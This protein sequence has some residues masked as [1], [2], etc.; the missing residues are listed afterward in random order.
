MK[1]STS[2]TLW[3]RLLIACWA[4]I[5]L[6]AN[7]YA[8]PRQ[9]LIHANS[10]KV[11]IRDG[12]IFKKQVWHL[13]PQIKP[14]IYYALEPLGEKKI[15]F[16]TDTDSISFKVTPGKK[17]DFMILLNNKDTCYTRISTRL[18][19]DHV[20]T[21]AQKLLDKRELKQDFTYFRQALEKEHPGLYR[22]KSKKEMDRLFDSCLVALDRPMRGLEFGKSIMFMISSLQDGHTGT[23][24][25]RLIGEYYSENKKMF[26]LTLYF[27]PTK[28]YVFCSN[29]KELPAESELLAIDHQPMHTII[30][31]LFSYL[32][33]D[34][35]IETK[36]RQMLNNGAF[37]YLYN[38]IFGNKSS[39]IVE[40]KTKQGE[41]KISSVGAQYEKE[42]ACDPPKG[43]GNTNKALD[44]QYPQNHVALLTIKTF[45]ENRLN[46]KENFR[47]F[48]ETS[49]QEI[50]TRKI[51]DLIIDLRGNGGGADDLGALLYAYLTSKPFNYF[52]AKESTTQKVS[53]K[54]NPLLGI[55]QPK[56]N[57]F[58][59]DVFFLIDGLS[60]STTADFCAIARSERR[61]KFIGEET[62][63]GY[64]G[65]T[66]GGR[67][68]IQLPNSEIYIIIPTFNYVHAVKKAHYK[69]R[70]I[71]PDYPITPTVSDMIQNK[72]VVLNF[73]LQ[74]A[75]QK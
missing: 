72:D 53:V 39:F 60:F 64:Y 30:K 54:E 41:I 14:D 58:R 20:N 32:S 67:K 11:D 25:P 16:Y 57:N 61:G 55:Q 8:Q 7:V 15:T 47:N 42:F 48:L 74:V 34:G 2:P 37:P 3:D 28:A 4:V 5:L 73:A 44:V 68:D 40:Y 10:T 71:I 24:I 66:S 19:K 27:T 70:G 63:G 59:G 31:E 33:S 22:Y 50:N 35:T 38:L 45:D 62:G 43:S 1:Q 56:E 26:P 51:T 29:I 36:K 13:S 18:P 46:G 6:T 65:Y 21:V 9:P 17:Y 75:T 52:A 23:D 12:E 49:F 69:D